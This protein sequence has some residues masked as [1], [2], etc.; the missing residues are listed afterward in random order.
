MSGMVIAE[1][2]NEVTG[3][4]ETA[5]NSCR[6]SAIDWGPD[7]VPVYSLYNFNWPKAENLG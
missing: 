5:H 4:T 3:T 2:D 1:K 6:P 7:P